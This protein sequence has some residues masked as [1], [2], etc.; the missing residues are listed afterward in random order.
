MQVN[1]MSVESLQA[2]MQHET[3][4]KKCCIAIGSAI[5]LAFAGIVGLIF[6]IWWGN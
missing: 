1:G 4:C 3:Q 5:H 2:S 6:A